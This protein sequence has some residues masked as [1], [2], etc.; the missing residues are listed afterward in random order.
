ML[1]FCGFKCAKFE[2]TI[3]EKHL[4]LNFPKSLS[5]PDHHHHL[6]HFSAFL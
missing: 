5:I 6:H 2:L 1:C 4:N 3:E